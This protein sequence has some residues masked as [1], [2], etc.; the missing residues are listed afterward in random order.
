[1][2]ARAQ[3]HKASLACIRVNFRKAPHRQANFLQ[4]PAKRPATTQGSPYSRIN[5][6]VYLQDGLRISGGFKLTMQFQNDQATINNQRPGF[7]G[8]ILNI[9]GVLSILILL[10]I[11]LFL[12]SEPHAFVF[13]FGHALLYAFPIIL[14]LFGLMIYLSVRIVRRMIRAMA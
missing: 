9:L 10:F 11:L 2:P 14:P 12:I 4:Q 5:L 6:Y 13:V 3:G 1:M 8:V 7:W